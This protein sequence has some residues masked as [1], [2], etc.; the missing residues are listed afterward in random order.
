MDRK[1]PTL[2]ID[3]DVRLR[4]GEET[5]HVGPGYP[6]PELELRG[7]VAQH[8][9][10]LRDPDVEPVHRAGDVAAEIGEQRGVRPGEQPPRREVERRGTDPQV[11]R[12]PELE[13]AAGA[14]MAEIAKLLRPEFRD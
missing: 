11:P 1:L 5:H 13:R 8:L 9:E 4:L 12:R 2:L 14:T 6:S 10:P 7:D 3:T